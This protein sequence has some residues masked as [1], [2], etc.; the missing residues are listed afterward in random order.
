LANGWELLNPL[1]V[2][3]TPATYRDFV[4]SSLAE[5]GLAKSG[6]VAARCG[7]FSDRSICYLASGRPVLAQ[8]TGFGAWL[9]T[10]EGVVPF[11][12]VEEAAIGADRIVADYD[13]HARTARALAQEFFDSDVV[14]SRLLTR[15]GAAS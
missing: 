11:T 4:R 12:S 13:R 15:V 7:W 14:L 2:A 9:P 10:G 8:D 5:F 1:E 6:Y 3:G